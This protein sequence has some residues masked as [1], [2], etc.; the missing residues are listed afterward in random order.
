VGWGKVPSGMA[1]SSELPAPDRARRWVFPAL[2]LGLLALLPLGYFL[3]L[4]S[5]ASPSVPLEA[6][7]PAPAE[8]PVEKAPAVVVSELSG[9]VELRRGGAEWVAA[10][11]G[12]ALQPTDALR[13]GAGAVA[14]LAGGEVWSVRM[15]P[16]TEIEVGELTSSISKVLLGAGMATA[17]VR[18]GPRH[19]FEVRAHGSDAVARTQEGAFAISNNGEGTVAVGARAGEVELVGAGQVVIVRAGQQS[20]VLP[21]QAPSEPAPIPGSL[22]LKVK[23]PARRLLTQR[24]LVLTGQTE[25]GAQVS[26]QG[27]AIRVDAKGQFRHSVSLAEGKNALEV[28]SVSVGGNRSE[29]REELRVDS[30]APKLGIDPNL[31]RESP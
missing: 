9:L 16:G 2:V 21:G 15:E 20:V 11:P 29:A 30:T 12:T 22:L 10:Q 1:A 3:I 27:A 5:G 13:T 18:G 24:K 26:V 19:T 7:V 6:A 17:T 25:P 4:G 8:E 23:W 28:R 14:V 31:W